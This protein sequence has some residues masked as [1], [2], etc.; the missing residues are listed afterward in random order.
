M[1]KNLIIIL[2]VIILLSLIASAVVVPILLIQSQSQT[3]NYPSC[4][5]D[6]LDKYYGVID[7]NHQFIM[8]SVNQCP[9]KPQIDCCA[10]IEKC[11]YTKSLGTN[12]CPIGNP[13]N[14]N[15]NSSNISLLCTNSTG[16]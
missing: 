14:C 11:N 2:A 7:N 5:F 4:S 12:S 10:I 13:C 8:C 3:A 9:I 16:R 6:N 1:Q 15:L